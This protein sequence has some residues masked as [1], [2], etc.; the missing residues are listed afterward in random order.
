MAK[1]IPPFLHILIFCL[2]LS[3]EMLHLCWKCFS[4]SS[5]DIC[6]DQLLALLHFCLEEKAV[7]TV[8]FS[9]GPLVVISIVGDCTEDEERQNS[10]A[11]FLCPKA[12]GWKAGTSIFPHV[13]AVFTADMGNGLSPQEMSGKWDGHCLAG[14][15]GKCLLLE[16]GMEHRAL[17]VCPDS[18]LEQEQ[19]IES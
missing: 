15:P 5:S 1:I 8:W 11:L 14:L 7:T 18:S 17:R 13:C 16:V 2:F 19:V 12:P 9:A 3:I 10:S 6:A 4:E